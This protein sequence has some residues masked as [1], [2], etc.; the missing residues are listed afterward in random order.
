M[1]CIPN[2]L[3]V[4]HLT[5]SEFFFEFLWPIDLLAVLMLGVL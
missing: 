5:Q 1:N 2:N 4:L 3:C